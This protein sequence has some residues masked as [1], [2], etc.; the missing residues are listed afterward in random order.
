MKVETDKCICNHV[1]VCGQ[2]DQHHCPHAK[3]HNISSICV[4]VTKCRKFR[5]VFC[6]P[7]VEEVTPDWE[8]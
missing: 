8:I 6:A 1:D 3:A 2:V 4:T 5:G 7:I